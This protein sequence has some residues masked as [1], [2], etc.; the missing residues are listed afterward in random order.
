M[1]FLRLGLV[2]LASAA[3][4]HSQSLAELAARKMYVTDSLNRLA[5]MGIPTG[6]PLGVPLP[7]TLSESDCQNAINVCQQTYTYSASPPN[8][9]AIQELG[10]NTC[11]LNGE[12]KTA[13]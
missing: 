4:L 12:Q 2:F 5:A 8:Y 9:G 10:N 7:L 6:P 1:F 11:L 13:W 3:Y